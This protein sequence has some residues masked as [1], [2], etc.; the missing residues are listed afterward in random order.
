MGA[1]WLVLDLWEQ[2][3]LDAFQ[4]SQPKLRTVTNKELVEGV[5]FEPT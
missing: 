2:L 5:G 1:R 3:Q 4:P